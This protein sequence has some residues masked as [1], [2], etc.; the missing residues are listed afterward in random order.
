MPSKAEIEAAATAIALQA[1]GITDENRQSLL[2]GT[3]VLD[4]LSERMRND[5]MEKARLA[6]EAAER[7]R[8]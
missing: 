1:G 3:S 5:I 2:Y 4:V 6:L 7:V 8:N